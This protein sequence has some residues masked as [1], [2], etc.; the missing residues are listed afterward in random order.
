MPKKDNIIRTIFTRLKQHALVS[1][2]QLVFASTNG[3]KNE[4]LRQLNVAPSAAYDSYETSCRASCF[5]GTRVKLL[6]E[7][8]SWVAGND[9]SL[10]PIYVLDGVAGIGKSTISKTVA[11]RA[12]EINALGASFFFSR[13]EEK[14]KTAKSFFPAIAFQLAHYEEDFAKRIDAALLRNPNA[15]AQGLPKQFSTMIVEP[16]KEFFA[17]TGNP[18][19]I[20]IDAL[21]ECEEGA[22]T[23]LKI[24]ADA[25]QNMPRLKVFITTRPERHI[26]IVLDRYRHL[27]RFHLHDIEASVVQSDI[28][29]Y[30][31]FHLSAEQVQH[32]LPELEQPWQPAKKDMDMLVNMSGKLFIIAST[33]T[34]FILDSWSPDPAKQLSCLLE[35]VSHTDFSGSKHT[36]AMD[37]FYM[38]ILHSALPRNPGNSNSLKN[39]FAHYQL[40]VGTILVLQHPL[41][42]HVLASLIDVS[43]TDINMA[44]LHLHSLVAPTD[45]SNKTFRIHHKSFPDFVTSSLRC[46]SEFLIDTK[47][48]HLRLGKQCL[49]IMNSCLKLNMCNLGLT[50]RY[51]DNSEI[52]HLTENCILQEVAYACTYWATHLVSAE[53][54]DS[55]VEQLLEC[56]ASKHIFAWLEVLS[57]IGKINIA[58]SS[59]DTIGKLLVSVISDFNFIVRY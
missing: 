22:D 11:E 32:A 10:A 12:A 50:E 2:F 18:I 43:F 31:E 59:L 5:R 42:G 41:P 47:K 57:T 28:R 44:L 45:D 35:D 30:L 38:Q 56:F 40:V 48:C 36:T 23:L 26:R 58:Y 9:E 13:D 39:W 46:S 34:R 7:I 29:L 52:Q 8:A 4:N 6:T 17:A 49:E 16:L 54:L 37:V 21:D 51:M 27:K 1:A 3:N 33:I 53:M 55:T 20:V 14:R 15:V 24:L 25:I 19:L